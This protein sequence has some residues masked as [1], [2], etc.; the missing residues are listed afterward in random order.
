MIPFGVIL[1]GGTGAELVA[2]AAVRGCSP[3]ILRLV[4]GAKGSWAAEA[5]ES[6]NWLPKPAAVTKP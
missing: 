6:D 5:A 2:L 3:K 1:E 4:M